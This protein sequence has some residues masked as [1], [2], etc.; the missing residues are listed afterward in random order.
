MS[1]TNSQKKYLRRLSHK[2][3]PVFQIGKQG[4]G[5]NLIKQTADTL[6]ARELIKINILQ[7]SAE[8]VNEAA[9]AIASAVDAEIV[10]TIGSTMVLY[11][12]SRN[13][14][15]IELPK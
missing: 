13:N 10:Q 4:L 1:L 11:K 2:Q 7:N 5:E 8:E 12:E 14:K 9:E 6:E 15:K 3:S